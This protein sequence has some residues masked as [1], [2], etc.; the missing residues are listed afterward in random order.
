MEE[1]LICFYFQIQR[2]H[3]K[4]QC[5][6]ISGRSV[7]AASVFTHS[8]WYLKKHMLEALNESHAFEI[9][10]AD[11]DFVITVPAIWDDTAKMFMREAAIKVSNLYL[12]L[13]F[14]STV[15]TCKSRKLKNTDYM[16]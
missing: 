6:D 5:V 4:T 14:M 12:C 15:K 2:V 8:I 13:S 9:T 11:I 16:M 7:D 1:L 3:R 10:I